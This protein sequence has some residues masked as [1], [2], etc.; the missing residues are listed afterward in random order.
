VSLPSWPDVKICGVCDPRDAE[1]AVAAGATHIG[2]IRIPGSRRTR[3]LPSARSVCEAAVGALRV[4][5]YADASLPTILREVES[6]GLDVVQLH[7]QEEPERAASLA[8]RGVEVWKVVKPERAEDLLTAARRYRGADLLLVEGRSD[9]GPWA[10]GSRF[11]WGEVAAA[12]DRLPPATLLG[13]AGG[14]TPENVGQAVRRF[15]PALV[16]VSSGVESA[17]GRKDPARVREFIR[18][19]RTSTRRPSEGGSGER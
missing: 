6:L 4:G 1:D 10:A 11:R 15:R 5:V 8:A 2:V 19:A 13:V 9:H 3:P 14:L 12:V 18:S 16:D 7:G 17:V